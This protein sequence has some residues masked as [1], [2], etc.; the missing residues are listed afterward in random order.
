MFSEMQQLQ[1][2]SIVNVFFLGLQYSSERIS[3]LEIKVIHKKPTV[4]KQI[5]VFFYSARK[6]SFVFNSDLLNALK[7]RRL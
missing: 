3:L 1:T 6:L 2:C 7:S 5:Q 4:V